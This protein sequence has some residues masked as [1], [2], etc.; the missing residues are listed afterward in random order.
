MFFFF[1]FFKET[2]LGSLC[3][4]VLFQAQDKKMNFTPKSV[5]ERAAGIRKLDAQLGIKPG[6]MWKQLAWLSEINNNT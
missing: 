6:S 5:P 4:L 2:V 3:S 1:F